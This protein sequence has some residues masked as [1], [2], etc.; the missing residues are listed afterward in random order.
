VKT[1]LAYIMASL[2]DVNRVS[3]DD[4]YFHAGGNPLLG[5]MMLDRIREVFG[6]T[7]TP[8]QLFEAPTVSV[9]AMEIERAE[10]GYRALQ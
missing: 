4:N 3:N 7:L 5:A 9:L 2:V 10:S 8:D 1:Q 6:V